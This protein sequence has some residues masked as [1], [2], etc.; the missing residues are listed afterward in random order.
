MKEIKIFVSSTFKDMQIER[1]MLK[2]VVKP[3]LESRYKKAGISVELVDLRWGLQIE[4][5]SEAEKEILQTCMQEIHDC[6]PFFLSFLGERYGWIPSDELRQKSCFALSNDDYSLLTRGSGM[7]VTEMEILYG[8]FGKD[9]NLENCIFCFRSKDSYN[10]LN[11]KEKEE[12]YADA[13]KVNQLKSAIKR[14]VCEFQQ[15]TIIDY[16]IALSSASTEEIFSSLEP[17]CTQITKTLTE[18]IDKQLQNLQSEEVYTNKLVSDFITLH[19]VNSIQREEIEQQILDYVMWSEPGII[20]LSGES[21]YGKSYILSS[22]Y[23]RLASQKEVIPI[24]YSTTFLA[25]RSSSAD[26]LESWKEQ[27]TRQAD[28]A[29]KPVFF[30]DA[31]EYMEEDDYSHNLSFLPENITVIISTREKDLTHVSTRNRRLKTIYIPPFTKD[32][33]QTLLLLLLHKSHFHISNTNL[34]LILDKRTEIITQYAYESPLWIYLVANTLINLDHTDFFATFTPSGRNITHDDYITSLIKDLAVTPKD[35]F[36]YMVKK[37]HAYFGE[38][39]V[40]RFLACLCMSRYGLT[41][42]DYER[43]YGNSQWNIRLFSNIL[44]WFSSIVYDINSGEKT[45]FRHGIIEE[46]LREMLRDK[47]LEMRHKYVETTKA[48]LEYNPEYLPEYLDQLIEIGN[49]S[50]LIDYCSWQYEY[51]DIIKEAIISNLTRQ[52]TK[53]ENGMIPIWD[54]IGNSI[55][56]FSPLERKV[57]EL[58]DIEYHGDEFNLSEYYWL[59]C[60]IGWQFMNEGMFA[61]ALP[62]FYILSEKI[63]PLC[64]EE[65][66]ESYDRFEEYDLET[67]HNMLVI[68]YGNLSIICKELGRYNEALHFSTARHQAFLCMADWQDMGQRSR[69]AGEAFYYFSQAEIHENWFGLKKDAINNYLKAIEIFDSLDNGYLVVPHHVSYII[70]LRKMSSW[71]MKKQNADDALKLAL[72]ALETSESQI[73]IC[74]ESEH[75]QDYLVQFFVSSLHLWDILERLH[76]PTDNYEYI[77]NNA[78][79][80]IQDIYPD[81]YSSS[82]FSYFYQ[83]IKNIIDGHNTKQPET[84]NE[85]AEFDAKIAEAKNAEKQKRKQAAINLYIEAIQIAE[86]LYKSSPHIVLKEKIGE[87]YYRIGFLYQSKSDKEKYIPLSNENLLRSVELGYADAYYLLAANAAEMNDPVS[88]EE[89]LQKGSSANSLQCL[90]AYGLYLIGIENFNLGQQYLQ[91]AIDRGSIE[92]KLWKAIFVFNGEGGYEKDIQDALDILASC[93]DENKIAAKIYAHAR[94]CADEI[95]NWGIPY[96]LNSLGEYIS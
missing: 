42:L 49:T 59:L 77:I 2:T 17:L 20:I 74:S 10:G 90:I 72:K 52:D 50:E 67:Y 96:K 75:M 94:W 40:S 18:K 53:C 81:R 78:W 11:E 55:T 34:K 26:V 79:H 19:S 86:S 3:Y 93:K 76:I 35:L 15:G 84:N 82:E 88:E 22:I 89:Y 30:L 65:E 83:S 47:I 7:S 39:N 1:D 8:A 41:L 21:G 85:M 31:A 92:A 70:A 4:K 64:D 6:H 43:I 45:I 37:S 95:K 28:E 38:E 80:K 63:G 12:Y 44:H 71:Y 24:F 9:A 29:F 54:R 57:R 51:D 66:P 13:D 23:K 69:K 5:E 68:C 87:T 58:I 73:H 56:S 61:T 46:T 25:K 60:R 32:E 16:H 27:W 14:K 33:S 91:E 62:L 36:I 48:H